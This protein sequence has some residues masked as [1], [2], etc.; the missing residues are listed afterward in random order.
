MPSGITDSR[1]GGPKDHINVR[2]LET[3]MVSGIP[4]C[5]GPYD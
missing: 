5:M 2:I 4:A 1:S 3:P